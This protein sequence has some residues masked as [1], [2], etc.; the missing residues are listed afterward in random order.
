MLRFI[1]KFEL[2][3]PAAEVST[4]SRL[5]AWSLVE[6][7]LLTFVH[8]ALVLH[9]VSFETPSTALEQIVFGDAP[10]SQSF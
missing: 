2:Q 8:S 5:S 10:N 9:S 7:S 6:Q 4:D 3:T 1:S